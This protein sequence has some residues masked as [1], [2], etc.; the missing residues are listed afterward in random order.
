MTEPLNS[1]DGIGELGPTFYAEMLVD[2]GGA[3]TPDAANVVHL[4]SGTL[5]KMTPTE[6]CLEEA[7]RRRPESRKPKRCIG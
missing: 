2:G 4:S 3:V 7:G 6:N 5:L 1:H